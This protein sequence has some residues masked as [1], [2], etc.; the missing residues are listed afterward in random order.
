MEGSSHIELFEKAGFRLRILCP[1]KVA[2]FLLLI[3]GGESSPE[4]I[5]ILAQKLFL[6]DFQVA[7]ATWL[8]DYEKF[9]NGLRE[10]LK[11]R[12]FTEIWIWGEGRG[13]LFGLRLALD[14]PG[15][16]RGLILDGFQPE[17]REEIAALLP[18]LHKP[19]LILHP[20]LD[21]KLPFTEVERLFI[22][23][24]AHAKKLLLVPGMRRGEVLRREAD[25]YVRTIAEFINPR[26]GRW[27]RK[28]GCSH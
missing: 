10:F 24:P 17:D 1:A 7:L 20:Q 11:K 5:E 23:S 19:H 4:V 9:R 13:A 6:E 21:E 18:G 27:P 26:T 2:P 3:P 22:L 25:L 8:E 14:L 12:N 16:V 28:F 15:E